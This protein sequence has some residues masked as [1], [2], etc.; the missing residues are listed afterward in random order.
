[1]LLTSLTLAV[2]QLGFA[3]YVR[4]VVHD[5]AVEGAYHAALADTDLASGAKRAD[6]LISRAVG[7]GYAHSATVAT[8]VVDGVEVAVVTITATLPLAGVL[9]ATRGWEVTAYAPRESLG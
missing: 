7:D 8:D 3:L 5:A 2:L 9:G 6:A 4:G 1:M